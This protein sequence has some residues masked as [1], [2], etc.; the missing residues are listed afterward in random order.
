MWA[1][2]RPAAEICERVSR[3]GTASL[4]GTWRGRPLPR[5]ESLDKVSPIA[6][7]TDRGTGRSRAGGSRGDELAHREPAPDDGVVLS[8]DKRKTQDS[9]RKQCLSL[10]SICGELPNS[11]SRV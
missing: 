11:F 8:S 6:D 9:D 7:A 3:S 1:L 4:G 10:R 2:A 5:Q